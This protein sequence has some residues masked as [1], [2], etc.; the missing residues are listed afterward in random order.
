MPP[1]SSALYY[2]SI[3]IRDERWLRTTALFWDSIRTIVPESI[4]QPYSGH[5]ARE[6]CGEGVLRPVRVSSGMEEIEELS[7]SVLDYLTDP[8]SAGVLFGL[9]TTLDGTFTLKN[10]RT[11]FVKSSKFIQ[12]NYHMKFVRNLIAP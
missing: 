10:Y 11:R 5:L 3:D 12:M 1:F 6:L 8:S 9:T 4:R 7:D 2:P